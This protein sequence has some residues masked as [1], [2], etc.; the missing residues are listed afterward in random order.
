VLGP[1]TMSG[2]G[3]L[4]GGPGAGCGDVGGVPD[5]TALPWVA[6]RG[7]VVVLG[8]PGWLPAPVVQPPT[9][10]P[11]AVP[12]TPRMARTT[13]RRSGWGPSALT[14]EGSQASLSGC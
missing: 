14:G 4:S 13:V 2:P 10:S 6:G 1:D 7:T 5:G 3:W 11:A 8:E 12:A 9:A